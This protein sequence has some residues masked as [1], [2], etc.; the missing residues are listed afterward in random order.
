MNMPSLPHGL[1]HPSSLTRSLLA[2]KSEFFWVGAFSLVANLLTLS[3]TLYMLQVFDR[4]MLS[5]SELTLIA[6]T[7]I[8]TVF[9]AVMAF[10]EWIRSRLLV[11]AGVRFDEQLNSRIFLA[12]FQANLAQ[13]RGDTANTFASL[14]R[15][16]QFLTG[17]GI[18]AFFDLPWT[19]I[20]IAVLFVM[21]PLLGW[22]AI[23]FSVFLGALAFVTSQLT[24][25]RV[26][27]ATRAE[28][29]TST[30]LSGKLR[31]AEVVEAMGMLGNL[32][33]RWLMLY[34]SHAKAPHQRHLS[35][36]TVFSLGIHT[37]LMDM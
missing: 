13:T 12:N 7:M 34:R 6:L 37:S 1:S 25:V 11:R 20:Y 28:S 2:F 36:E 33:R 21:H 18:I 16:R 17:N 5:Q 31:N 27:Q 4:V 29:E 35:P 10:A 9:V 8:T 19:P 15:L 32:K 14:T 3:P 24:S 26:E 30:Y 23:V 22:F